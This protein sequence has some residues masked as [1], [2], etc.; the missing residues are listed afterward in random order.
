MIELGLSRIQQLLAHTPLPWRA[1]HVSGTN[2]KGSVCA[3]ITA[4]LDIYNSSA[5]RAH[6]RHPRLR[7]GRFTTPHLIS[8]RDSVAV[9]GLAVSDALFRT[10]EA[11][12]L[13]RGV[14][15]ATE[16]E[17]LTAVAFEVFSRS[18]V[19]VGVVEVG[20]GGRLDA[21]NVLG[22][23]P[24]GTQ[25]SDDADADFRPA[26][27]ATGIT[28][29]GLDHVE[30]LGPTLG[31]IAREKAGIVKRGVPVVASA[32][33]AEDVRHVISETARERHVSDL[34]YVSPA[35]TLGDV[36]RQNG[37]TE[38]LPDAT[39]PVQTRWA[40]GAVALQLTWKALR[41]LGRLDGVPTPLRA[42]LMRSL[43]DAVDHVVWHGRLERVDLSPIVG[44]ECVAVIDG[45]HNADSANVL[46]RFLDSTA[47]TEQGTTWIMAMSGQ[48]KISEL[49]PILLRPGDTL[50]A[51]EFG[52]VEGM[53]W[54]KPAKSEDIVQEA[55]RITTD[56]SSHRSC[57]T[58]LEP[59]LKE[60]CESAVRQRH[61]VV[62][63]GSLYLVG[64]MYKLLRP[65]APEP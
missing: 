5:A 19:D 57:R 54:I 23:M 33:V 18:R 30:F 61:R 15:A 52:P 4:L 21:T 28:D 11:D 56:S 12:V 42:E 62:V 51:V 3:T 31:D 17:V 27:L 26:P 40:N 64:E 59:A 55:A 2:G 37:E 20:M 38:P 14:V 16:F 9:D 22:V 46:R 13:S 65:Y 60:A 39:K 24:D 1:I 8:R 50:Y 29:I 10:V 36:W 32:P 49:L 48:K 41:R 44:R 6:T 58:Q 43:A 45:A 35:T 25:P 34:V 53:P 63:T 47:G 7:H